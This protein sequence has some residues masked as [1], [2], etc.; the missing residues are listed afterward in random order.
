MKQGTCVFVCFYNDNIAHSLPLGSL[1]L[2]QH[3]LTHF[4]PNLIRSP[5]W[6]SLGS[7]EQRDTISHSITDG[8]FA[9][10]KIPLNLWNLE[11][12]FISKV[13]K[14]IQKNFHEHASD[15]F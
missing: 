8:F 15:C 7:L 5:I 6:D 13:L 10:Y 2:I 14:D 4:P 3:F 9:N 12:N 11:L 1:S